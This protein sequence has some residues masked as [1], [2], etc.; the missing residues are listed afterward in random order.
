MTFDEAKKFL[1][2]RGF[3][4]DNGILRRPSGGPYISEAGM[5]TDDECDVIPG[6]FLC[7]DGDFSIEE[8]EAIVVYVKGREQQP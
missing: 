8:L 3:I 7:L 2:D 6:V 1:A 5:R 4:G